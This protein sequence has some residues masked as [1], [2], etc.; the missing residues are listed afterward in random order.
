MLTDPLEITGVWWLPESPETE[1]AGTLRYSPEEG[2]ILELIGS[3]HD[4]TEMNAPREIPVVNGVAGGKNV[5]LTNLHT[6]RSNLQIPGVHLSTLRAR[7]AFVGNIFTSLDS[8]QFS[9]VSVA[10]LHLNAWLDAANIEISRPDNRTTTIT[11]HLPEPA[12]YELREGFAI[13]IVFS[14]AGPGWSRGSL[15][16]SVRQQAYVRFDRV[17]PAEYDAFVDSI[18]HFQHLLSLAVGRHCPPIS[19][20]A[21]PS[22]TQDSHEP[23]QPLPSIEIIY[24]PVDPPDTRSRVISPQMFLPYHHVAPRLQDIFHRW[25]SAGDGLRT[26]FSLFFATKLASRMFLENRFLGLVQS[27]ESFHRLTIAGTRLPEDE[28][29][30]RLQTLSTSVSP[31][32][33]EWLRASMMYANEKTLRTR[34]TELVSQFPRLSAQVLGGSPHATVSRVVDTRNYLTHYDLATRDRAAV[35]TDLY[36]S[37]QQ[38]TAFMHASLIV[39]LGFNHTA[40]EDIVLGQPDQLP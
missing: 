3:F 11:V 19:L 33:A 23:R 20:Q 35:G 26:V 9:S 16:A 1:I 30:S 2:I 40:A 12:R 39:Y 24:Q 6:I 37:I 21:A 25:F 14:Q 32:L 15:E 38:L 13:S 4:I 7:F 10:Y 31:E 28:F 17:Q 18:R 22:T 36:R 34:L 29:R 5:T 27:M 8:I